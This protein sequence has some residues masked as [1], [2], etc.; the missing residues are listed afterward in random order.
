[1]TSQIFQNKNIVI[2]GA[3]SGIGA[4]C[5]RSFADDGAS[6]LLVDRDH[7]R[8]GLVA[9]ELN[10]MDFTADVRSENS[11]IEMANYAEKQFGV[12]HAVVT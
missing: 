2:T 9:K 5:A 12:V 10:A 8:L 4:A 7:E 1:M 11:I 6:L 3:A